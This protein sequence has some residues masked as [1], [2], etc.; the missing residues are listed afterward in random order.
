MADFQKAFDIL[1]GHEGGYQRNPN[2]R[3]NYNSKGELVGT[4]YG[5]SAPVYEAWINRP[6]TRSEME[7]LPFEDA[8][9]IYFLWYWDPIQGNSIE[10]QPVANIF[11]DGVVNH[12][13]SRGTKLMQK[14]LGVSQDGIVGPITL[15]A[16][17]SGNPANIYNQYKLERYNFYHDIVKRNPSQKVFLSGWI[18]RISSFTAYG[19][20]LPQAATGGPWD[21]LILA[22]AVGLLLY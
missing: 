15:G 16:I 20:N 4:N 14:V 7:N 17:N 13:R 1:K 22:A 2:D 12:G 18:K 5:I 8:I 19:N 6:P 10:N 9:R 3:G 11:M 21:E